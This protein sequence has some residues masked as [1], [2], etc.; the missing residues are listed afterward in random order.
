MTPLE[1]TPTERSVLR[2]NPIREDPFG[3]WADSLKAV[4]EVNTPTPLLIAGLPG[5]M[6]AE[7]AGL[8]AAAPDLT[9]L[10]QGL[11]GPIH[12]GERHA[13]G[14]DW[15]ELIGDDSRDGLALPAGTI[16]VDYTTPEAALDNAR[17]YAQQSVPF[18][19]GTTGYDHAAARELVERSGIVAVIAPNMAPPIV[20]L[21]AAARWLAE[22]FPAAMA[23]ARLSIRESHQQGKRDTSGT[24]KALVASLNVL[25][26]DFSVDAIQKLRDP[27]AQQA[28]LRVPEACL[29]GHAYHRYELSAAEGTVDLVLEHNVRGRR[30]YA[31]GTLAAVRFLAERV[32]ER[33]RGRVYSME[34]VL[35][36]GG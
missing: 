3:S 25:G 34:D 11:T 31:E 21:Q 2:A 1:C 15:V 20:L 27:A 29:A 33:V 35:R 5:K 9:L 12:E 26:V 13:F 7:V 4:T 14:A 19:M 23:D 10:P 22:S 6:A 17:W 32:E 28:E 24:A 36:R 30:V 16:A 8:A 18:V